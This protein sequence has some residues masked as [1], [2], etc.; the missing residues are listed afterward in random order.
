LIKNWKKRC[1]LNIKK[2]ITGSLLAFVF[3]SIVFLFYKESA[4]KGKEVNTINDVQAVSVPPAEKAGPAGEIPVKELATK[5]LKAVQ[6]VPAVPA[7][8]NAKVTAYYFHGTNRCTTCRTIER[9]S[10]EAIE[11]YFAKELRNKTLEFKV[12]NVENPENRHYIQDYQLFSSSLVIALYKD[13][14]Q[15][16]WKNL[17][18]VWTY[19]KDKEKFYQYVKAETEK[20]L[21]ETE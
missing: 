6:S 18:D 2:L 11:K 7:V 19:V 16:T 15:A 4:Q 3:L 21:R 12:L 9:Y 13:D 20:F 14:K 5:P 1:N 17:T 8:K 10:H